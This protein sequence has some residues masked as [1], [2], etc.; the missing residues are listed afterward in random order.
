MSRQTFAVNSQRVNIFGFPREEAKLRPQ[1]GT[2]QEKIN[3]HIIPSDKIQNKIIVTECIVCETYLLMR[4]TA[5]V[6]CC[7]DSD[8]VVP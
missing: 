6:K 2:Q 3:F 5:L 1:I 8:L 4:R 7:W